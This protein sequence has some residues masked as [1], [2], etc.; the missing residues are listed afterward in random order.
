MLAM[1]PFLNIIYINLNFYHN[2]IKLWCKDSL[3]S[4]YTGMF[5]I[6]SNSVLRNKC[7]NHRPKFLVPTFF[8]L[9]TPYSP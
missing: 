6:N 1:V 2:E 4:Y 3:M 5:K 7:L 9:L 8:R